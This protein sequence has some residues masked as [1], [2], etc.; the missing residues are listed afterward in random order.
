MR[1]LT[2]PFFALSAVMLLAAPWVINSAP[3]ESTMGLVQKI[4]SVH[5]PSAMIFMVTSVLCGVAS[6]VFLMGGRNPKADRIA[7]APSSAADRVR[8]LRA[9]GGAAA[10]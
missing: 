10:R 7:L 1:K 4:F 9:M 5:L 3:Y 6:A 8:R 2:V